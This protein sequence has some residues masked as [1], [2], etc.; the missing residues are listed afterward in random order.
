M[1]SEQNSRIIRLDIVRGRE[2]DKGRRQKQGAS[3]ILQNGE[4]R[5]CLQLIQ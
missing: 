1:V 2:V 3:P 5:Y 4:L